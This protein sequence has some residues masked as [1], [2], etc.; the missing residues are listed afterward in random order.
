MDVDKLM[1]DETMAR[2]NIVHVNTYFQ[3][4]NLYFDCIKAIG[5]FKPDKNPSARNFLSSQTLELSYG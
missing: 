2:Q 5:T 4:L 1:M 3:Q